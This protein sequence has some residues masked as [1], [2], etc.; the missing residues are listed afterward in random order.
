MNNWPL[1]R[2]GRFWDG[3]WGLSLWFSN[4][5]VAEFSNAPDSCWN[6]SLRAVDKETHLH[7]SKISKTSP[8]PETKGRSCSL[9]T[10]R[11]TN[12]QC[13]YAY[14]S[15]ACKIALVHRRHVYRLGLKTYL[16]FISL[17]IIY[18]WQTKTDWWNGQSRICRSKMFLFW[19]VRYKSSSSCSH[20]RSSLSIFILYSCGFS[21]AVNKG[22]WCVFWQ[23]Q[24]FCSSMILL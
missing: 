5:K 13:G 8:T 10:D 12:L 14:L 1:K 6:L 4:R 7:V 19:F 24:I 3:L 11:Y 23:G 22:K 9:S 18:Q 17:L 15:L 20:I 16:C 2:G 21:L